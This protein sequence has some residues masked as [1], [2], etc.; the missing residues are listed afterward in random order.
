[1]YLS[2]LIS[3]V[4]PIVN[5]TGVLPS[6]FLCPLLPFAFGLVRL[7][8]LSLSLSFSLSLSLSLSPSRS[9]SLGLPLHLYLSG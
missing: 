8:L 3:R 1:M 4:Q 2:F 6:I 5:I 7:Q 9:L